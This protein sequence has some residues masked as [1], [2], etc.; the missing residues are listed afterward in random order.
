MKLLKI[1]IR[2]TGML[3][4]AAVLLSAVSLISRRAE[5]NFEKS[6]AR[7]LTGLPL[8]KIPHLFWWNA[9]PGVPETGKA[10]SRSH[11]E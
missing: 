6:G 3:V 9:P 1:G 4:T 11:R 8:L 5:M 2:L 7:Y 10:G